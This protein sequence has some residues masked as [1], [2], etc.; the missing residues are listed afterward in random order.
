[1]S[2]ITY[3]NGTLADSFA[4]FQIFEQSVRDLSRRL[5]VS[6][7]T[8]GDDPEV[9]AKLWARRKP[10]FDHLTKTAERFYIAE[11]EGQPIAYARSIQRSGLWELTD[12]FVLPAYQSSGI[13][14]ELFHRV[15]P[16]GD[17]KHK[18]IIATTDARA[19]ARYLKAGVYARFPLY[20]FSKKP[21]PVT[22]SSSLKFHPMTVNDETINGLAQI[23]GQILGH[24][25]DEDHRWLLGE[26]R[27]FLYQRNGRLVGYGYLGESNGPFAL[28]DDTD[29]PP[30]LAHAESEAAENGHE[31]GVEVP[32]INKAAVNY[33]LGRGFRMDS[34]FAFF[35]S[36]APFGQFDHYLFPSPPFFM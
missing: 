14:R 21:E 5:G 4:V 31:F 15:I 25:R 24:R 8:G 29:F 2:G 28:M 35:M 16:T 33:L 13:G 22:T 23:D 20:Y 12:Y 11:K 17:Y 9:M 32:L 34:F 10:L 27:G 1:M 26:R 6:A 7:I 36:D 19:Q 18:V 30:I 3:R